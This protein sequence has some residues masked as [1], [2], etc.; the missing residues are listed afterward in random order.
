MA[1][2]A[3][4]L[5]MLFL[6]DPVTDRRVQSFERLFQ[7]AGW[8]VE[9]LAVK[10]VYTHGPRKF[11]E[12]HRKLA[13]AVIG[14]RADIVM[15]CD[16]YSLSVA[17]WMRKNGRAKKLVY[18]AREV[19]TELPAVAH[20]PLRRAIWKQV[21]HHGLTSTDIIVVTAPHDLQAILDVHGFIPRSMLIRNLPWKNEM[22]RRHQAQLEDYGIPVGSNVVVYLGG[23]QQGR[24]LEAAVQ[25]VVATAAH[26]FMIGDGALRQTIEQLAVKEGVGD[27][28]H[29][30]G[31]LPSDH[32]LALA[33]SCDVGLVIV[34]PVSKSYELA[35][36]SKL[37]EYMMAGIPIVTNHMR[38]VQE[39]FEDKPWIE[40]VSITPE[41]IRAGITKAMKVSAI[42][43]F[44]EKRL[45]LQRYHFASDA[46]PLI[47]LLDSALSIQ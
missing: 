24:G 21:E 33:A 15:A 8:N 17:A 12:Y 43:R 1:E 30:A 47:G 9:L 22:L 11:S 44:E 34:E 28:V 7:E 5:L 42:A 31:A 23:L 46:S 41:A 2:S 10:L 32:A 16:L 13:R 45:A 4:S 27:Q 35:L 6:G 38:H 37:F 40:F 20:K 36:P 26:L 39:L 19:Y 14:K 29:F 25:S 3:K 18:D